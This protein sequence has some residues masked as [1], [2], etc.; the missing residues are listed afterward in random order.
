M[1]EKSLIKKNIL[2]FIDYKE[3][4][5]YKFYQETGITRG[6]LDQNNG[7]S[8]ENTAKFLAYYPEV[9]PEWL[10]TGKGEMLKQPQGYTNTEKPPQQV[11]E[12][13]AVYQSSDTS[14]LQGQI[15]FLKR[16]IEYLQDKISLL[17]ENKRLLED[18]IKTLEEKESNYIQE[19]K[20]T[21]SRLEQENHT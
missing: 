6:I 9:S 7:M 19:L 14:H 12:P 8:E 17:Q 5:K 13:Q 11:A 1:Q 20:N 16:E 18:K 21:I 3:I 10:L 2:Q 15:S 4:T